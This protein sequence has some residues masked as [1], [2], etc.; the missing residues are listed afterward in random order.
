MAELTPKTA[1]ELELQAGM[2][3]EMLDFKARVLLPAVGDGRE[4]LL[5]VAANRVVGRDHADFH[6]GIRNLY[7]L[8][9]TRSLA[10]EACERVIAMLVNLV[11]TIEG[12]D[13]L[14][15]PLTVKAFAEVL[16]WLE[17]NVRAT[18]PEWADTD[19]CRAWMAEEDRTFGE[20]NFTS[21]HFLLAQ[22]IT[23]YARQPPPDRNKPRAVRRHMKS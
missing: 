1:S 8:T 14:T 15:H 16:F 19:E 12:P 21:E 7:A 2:T 5:Q 6:V 4:G 11:L 22:R 23:H 13:M 17:R 3:P 18:P 9:T 10:K 20:W